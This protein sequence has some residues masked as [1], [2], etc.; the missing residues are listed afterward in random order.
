MKLQ[1]L[2]FLGMTGLALLVAAC[3][4]DKGNYDYSPVNHLTIE[5]PA[6]VPVLANADT[7]KVIPKVVSE[8]EGEILPDNPNYAYKYQGARIV[9]P[10]SEDKLF[11]LDSTFSRDLIIPAKWIPGSYKCWLEV[12]DLRTGVVSAASFVITVSSVTTEGWMVLCDEGESNRVRLDMIAR[13]S[14][15]RS[16]QTYDILANYLPDLHEAYSLEFFTDLYG[17]DDFIYLLSGSGCYQLEPEYLVSGPE[18]LALVTDPSQVEQLTE[19]ESKCLAYLKDA[20]SV[21]VNNKDGNL[22]I[23]LDLP[24]QKLSAYLTNRA[25]AMLQTYIARFRIAKAQAAL[26]FVEERYTEVKN[27]LEKKQQALVQFREKHPDRTSVQLETEEKILT[28]DYELFFGLYSDIVKQREKAKIQVKE[29]MPVLT[30]IEPVVEPTVPSKP[31]RALSVLAS[32]LLGLF[33]GCGFVLVQPIFSQIV[34][35]KKQA[36]TIPIKRMKKIS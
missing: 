12:T 10:T 29:D 4:D 20:F 19:E 34:S 18:R 6:E 25:Q 21:K 32:L 2:F 17:M 23:T 3:F 1:Y 28:N 13:I 24:D 35:S 14:D 27:E 11:V 30:V 9:S 7:I 22:K 8:L 26:D 36:H 31:Q 15:E 33:V 16:V 5:V